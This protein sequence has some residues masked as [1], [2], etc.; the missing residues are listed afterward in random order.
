MK[1]FTDE[2]QKFAE[3]NYGLFWVFV[4]EYNAI[5]DEDIYT[6]IFN[7]YLL[8]L[9]NWFKRDDLR[10]Y[11]FSTIFAWTVKSYIATHNRK[12]VSKAKY[13]TQAD[14]VIDDYDIYENFSDFHNYYNDWVFENELNS[15]L[16]QDERSLVDLILSGYDQ[17]EIA[18]MYDKSQPCISRR[19]GKIRRKL[20]KHGLTG[21]CYEGSNES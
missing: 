7:G 19:L 14:N 10:K 18:S 8:A 1:P 17:R 21:A 12:L 4:N 9:N 6:A 20:R 3:D 13:L 11:S 2:Q 16:T 5:D 15:V